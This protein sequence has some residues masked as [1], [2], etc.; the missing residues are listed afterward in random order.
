VNLVLAGVL[1][2]AHGVGSWFDPS[3]AGSLIGELVRMMAWV[4]VALAGFNLIPAFPMDGGRVLRALLAGRMGRLR[5]TETAASVGQFL[6]L[7]LPLVLLA[8]GHLT[9]WNL[10][11][12]GFVYFAAAA[13]RAAV[14]WEAMGETARRGWSWDGARAARGSSVPPAGYRWVRR[15]PGLWQ[16]VPVAVYD[17]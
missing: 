14:R 10:L 4:N 5:A 7:T 11:L 12:A 2:A 9:F 8:T 6:A 15:G 1:W 13:E 16:L 17:E 3:A